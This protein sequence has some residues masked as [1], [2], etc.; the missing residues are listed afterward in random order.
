MRWREEIRHS[1]WTCDEMKLELGQDKNERLAQRRVTT[2]LEK[3]AAEMHARTISGVPKPTNQLYT[4]NDDAKAT[5]KDLK[6]T[7]AR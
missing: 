2:A 1:V 7:L 5:L 4:S 3:K 6:D